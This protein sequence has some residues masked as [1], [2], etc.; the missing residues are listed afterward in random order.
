[1]ATRLPSISG[2]SGYLLVPL[3]ERADFTLYRGRWN[4]NPSSV[5]AVALDAEQESPQGLW[6][7]EHEYSLAAE[8]D[9][10]W[11]ATYAFKST[12]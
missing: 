3:Q 5:L 9:S 12:L 10:A 11:A 2:P 7:L 4:G 1:M 8:L 6:R